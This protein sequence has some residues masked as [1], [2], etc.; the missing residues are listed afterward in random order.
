[1]EI[2]KRVQD[3][4]KLYHKLHIVSLEVNIFY[5]KLGA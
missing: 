4:G 1:M 5:C 3:V 2:I